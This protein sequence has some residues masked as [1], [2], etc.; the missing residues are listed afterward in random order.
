M[1]VCKQWHCNKLATWMR[2]S[3]RWILI[4][5]IKKKSMANPKVNLDIKS[6]DYT[7]YSFFHFNE[8]LLNSYYKRWRF[9]S[10]ILSTHRDTHIYTPFLHLPNIWKHHLGERVINLPSFYSYFAFCLGDFFFN[11]V[12]DLGFA[13]LLACFFVCVSLIQPQ[14]FF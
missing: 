1:R 4:L 5:A 7:I 12:I 11:L 14:I 13:C 8:Y 10:F 6:Y 2:I 3:I 9:N